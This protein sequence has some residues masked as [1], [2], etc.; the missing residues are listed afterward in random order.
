MNIETHNEQVTAL[1]VALAQ[2]QGV[3][4]PAPKDGHNNFL[5]VSYSSLASA[6]GVARKP[7][8]EN[9]LCFSQSCSYDPAKNE[10]SVETTLLHRGGGALVNRLSLPVIKQPKKGESLAGPVTVQDIAAA[11]T[12]A[13]RIGFTSIVGVVSE[14]ED[15]EAQ[16]QPAP[17][18]P[19]RWQPSAAEQAFA[20]RIPGV[21]D[22]ESL[23]ALRTEV[24][25][26]K[27]LDRLST[28]RLNDMMSERAKALKASAPQVDTVGASS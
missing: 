11:F 14:N 22:I 17:P 9:G 2:A 6:V 20:A 25:L 8:A 23:R 13:K 3:M 21:G 15:A 10:V 19:P 16:T 4:S 12:T 28:K 5:N 27:G 1:I 7:L 26:A 18:A 24:A